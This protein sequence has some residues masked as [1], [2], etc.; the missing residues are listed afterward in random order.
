MSLSNFNQER[1]LFHRLGSIISNW[2]VFDRAA[3]SIGQFFKFLLKRTTLSLLLFGALFMCSLIGITTQNVWLIT[4]AG[5]L[6]GT[7]CL[8]FFGFAVLIHWFVVN[9]EEL[10]RSTSL[11]S[12]I[13]QFITYFFQIARR[14]TFTTAGVAISVGHILTKAHIVASVNLPEDLPWRSVISWIFIGGAPLMGR[15][16]DY[17]NTSAGEMRFRGGIIY[18]LGIIQFYATFTI[19]TTGLIGGEPAI[20][21]IYYV[22]REPSRLFQDLFTADY[23]TTHAHAVYQGVGS[24]WFIFIYLF[25]PG[26]FAL[27]AHM[28]L[29]KL[30]YDLKTAMPPLGLQALRFAGVIFLLIGLIVSWHEGWIGQLLLFIIKTIIQL[31]YWIEGLMK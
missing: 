2:N 31:Y 11:G 29:R 17:V 4:L 19:L 3:R 6:W 12:R 14:L 16:I 5:L 24:T 9:M 20:T 7:V 30:K 26:T 28:E 27:F 25:V 21:A 1:G 18:L 15:L 10:F 8:A 13:D 23:L 22:I